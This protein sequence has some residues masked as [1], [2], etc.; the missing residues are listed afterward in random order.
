MSE[1]A[2]D[3]P[4]SND[5][6]PARTFYTWRV[7]LAQACTRVSIE[8]YKS[9]A[10]VRSRL[11]YEVDQHEEVFQVRPWVACGTLVSLDC[12]RPVPYTPRSVVNTQ[13]RLPAAIICIFLC[14]S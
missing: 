12:L 6:A 8:L 7:D 11:A 9:A 4:K 2:Q 13:T 1:S 3:I 5:R 14:G 10:N